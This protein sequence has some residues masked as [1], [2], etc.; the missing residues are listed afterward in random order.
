MP[1]NTKEILNL[2]KMSNYFHYCLGIATE[3]LAVLLLMS[4]PLVISVIALRLWP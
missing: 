4:I 2:T 1:P 3:S